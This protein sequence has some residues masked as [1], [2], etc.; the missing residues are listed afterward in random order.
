LEKYTHPPQTY[1]IQ[2]QTTFD[3]NIYLT[4]ERT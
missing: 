4:F 3:E 2:I 1:F